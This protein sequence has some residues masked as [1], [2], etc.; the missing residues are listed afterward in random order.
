M[1]NF[2]LMIFSNFNV[3]LYHWRALLWKIIKYGKKDLEE[4]DNEQTFCLKIA[5]GSLLPILN[6]N[7][8]LR[9]RG[10]KI[11]YTLH[12]SLSNQPSMC[13][14]TMGELEAGKKKTVVYVLNFKI[15]LHLPKKE[16][17]K[18]PYHRPTLIAIFFMSIMKKL[19]FWHLG[20]VVCAIA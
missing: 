4:I 6:K 16:R 14:V 20:C 11:G 9:F 12:T 8:P 5:L 1:D 2:N 10:P 7:I 3:P 17:N 18:S 15:L 19:L 13:S